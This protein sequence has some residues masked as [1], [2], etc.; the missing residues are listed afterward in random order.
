MKDTD[1]QRIQHIKT[2]CE[3]IAETIAR[4]G[5]NYHVF[6]ADRDF[7]N[8]VSMSIMQI[9]ELSAGLSDTFKD[10]TRHQIQWG[11]L[12]G[13]RNLFAHAYIAMNKAVIWESAT[14]DVPAVLDFCEKIIEQNEK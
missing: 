8:S 7:I 4:F 6:E 13:M 11:A 9:G 5:N 1:L 12:K 2:Y 14:R 10:T 3:D